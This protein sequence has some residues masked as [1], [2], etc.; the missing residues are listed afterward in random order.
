MPRFLSFYDVIILRFYY[1]MWPLVQSLA[2]LLHNLP[3]VVKVLK[4]HLETSSIDDLP[5]Y[6]QLVSVLARYN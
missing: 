3:Q 4:E 1:G 6:L 5:S 2:E